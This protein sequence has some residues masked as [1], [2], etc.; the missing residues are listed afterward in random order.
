[1][2]GKTLFSW[3]GVAAFVVVAVVVLH[4]RVK[5]DDRLP[6][7]RKVVNV[8]AETGNAGLS[9]EAV[10]A[11]I[12][13][14]R[15]AVDELQQKALETGA[16]SE[17]AAESVGIF[18]LDFADA[19]AVADA[20]QNVWPD[21]RVSVQDAENRLVV[22]L[23]PNQIEQV[24]RTIKTLDQARQQV[25]ISGY[26]F[27]VE[28]QHLAQLGLRTE[29]VATQLNADSQLQ[30]L[31][32]ALMQ[33]EE[34]RLLARPSIRTY[35]RAE[36]SFQSVREIPVQNTTITETTTIGTTE[37]REVGISL[38]AAPRITADGAILMEVRS[39]YAVLQGLVG[40]QPI[41]DRRAAT[42]TL[43]LEDGEPI[44]I[45]GL[46]SLKQGSTDQSA[47]NRG[48]GETELLIILK[49]EIISDSED[50]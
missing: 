23:P 25:H 10:R 35:D 20:L 3:V 22:A 46:R 17:S 16:K 14:L 50:Q 43:K 40:N 28:V 18:Q 1:M 26:L 4:K 15:E 31:L 49:A 7:V 45:A 27:E 44:M 37:F 21:L 6:P 42:T 19:A 12:R 34:A 33:S 2:N 5:S 30:P 11:E 32:A 41:I 9:L 48:D 24:S 8:S 29:H 47:D 39:E 36:A 13:A 38:E